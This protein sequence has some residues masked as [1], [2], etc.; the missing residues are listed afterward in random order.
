MR[1]FFRGVGLLASESDLDSDLMDDIFSFLALMKAFLF[2]ENGVR[3]RIKY[4]QNQATKT[5]YYNGSVHP[6]VVGPGRY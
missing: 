6:C 2:V 5:K 4:C 1:P 3:E